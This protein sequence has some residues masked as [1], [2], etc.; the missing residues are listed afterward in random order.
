[1]ENEIYLKNASKCPEPQYLKLLG[2]LV[3]KGV[4][5]V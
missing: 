3:D 5:H 4:R 2:Y 1:M